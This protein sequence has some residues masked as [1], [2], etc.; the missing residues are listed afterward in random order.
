MANW[1]VIVGI[2][3]YWRPEACLK[4]AV[5]DA[6]DFYDWARSVDGGAVP[7]A[8]LFLALEPDPGTIRTRV[9]DGSHETAV[10]IIDQLIK[11]SG[12]GGDRL[13]FYFAGHGLTSRINFSDESAL[14]FRDF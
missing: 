9:Y 5:R 11:R 12:G 3:T 4:G 14:V 7:T 8:N 1:A 13:F 6:L 10:G 2:N